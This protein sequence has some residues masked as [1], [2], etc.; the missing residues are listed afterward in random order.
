VES[1]A[2]LS[3]SLGPDAPRTATARAALAGL[4]P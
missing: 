4:A 3:K 2:I 1:V